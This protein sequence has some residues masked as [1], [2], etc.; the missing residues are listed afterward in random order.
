MDPIAELELLLR[1][2][3][4]G[5]FLVST[6]REEQLALQKKLYSARDEAGVKNAFRRNLERIVGAR[7]II[8]GVPSDVGAG[9]RRGANLGP[10]G[11]RT[12]L[13]R[14]LPTFARVA[15]EHRIVDIGDV[16]VVPQLLSDDMLSNKQLADARAALY[17]GVVESFP[18]SPLS[19]TERVLDLVLALNPTVVPFILG[20]DHSVAWPV[21][22]AL[23]ACDPDLAIV[24]FDAHT[25]LLQSRL[26]VRYCFATWSFHA[27]ELIGRQGRMVQIGIRATQRD[28]AHWE[29]TTGVRQFWARDCIAHPEAALAEILAYVDALG[30]K[31]IY[32][33]NDIDGTD[34]AFADATGTPETGGLSPD[35]VLSIIRGLGSRIVAADIMEVA[36]VLAADPTVTLRTAVKYLLAQM[37]AALSITVI[38]SDSEG[39]PQ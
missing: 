15:E 37:E 28:Q 16:F 14:A 33:S 4:G 2:A 13:L 12:E 30:A 17:P 20:G 23:Y 21:T 25:D 35:F 6:G 1:P 11:I 31:R 24:Q 10:Q 27:N 29:E 26:G 8:L 3:G 19:I 22:K 39:P 36:P 5:V 9:Y 32:L 34:A 7:A 18:V 38:P